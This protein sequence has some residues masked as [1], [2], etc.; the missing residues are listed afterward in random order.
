MVLLVSL[1]PF[2]I[3]IGQFIPGRTVHVPSWRW[4]APYRCNR[5]GRW[6]MT[7]QYDH[8]VPKSRD[9]RK[10]IR[11]PELLIH[12]QIEVA[13]ARLLARDG[14][15]FKHSPIDLMRPSRERT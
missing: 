1:V 13:W 11:K 4:T 8:V 9:G 2:Y 5:Y 15:D 12:D 7:L 6:S 10:S 3:F 14:L